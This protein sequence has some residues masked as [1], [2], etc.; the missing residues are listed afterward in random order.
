MRFGGDLAVV[1][2][3]WAVGVPAVSAGL[4]VGS[5]LLSVQGPDV[6]AATAPGRVVITL[7]GLAGY[8]V[9]LF[10][11]LRYTNVIVFF[12]AFLALFTGLN[13][14]S[15]AVTDDALHQRGE[16]TSCTVR[17]VLPVSVTSSDSEGRTQTRIR[18]AYDLDCAVPTVTA[19]ST[20]RRVAAPG[21]RIDVLYD[22]WHR[23]DPRIPDGDED[24][25]WLPGLLLLA[26]AAGL[27]LLCEYGVWPFR[28]HW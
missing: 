22:P 21:D 1:R 11:Q 20:D 27:R 24:S 5:G 6:L 12:G 19:M 10:S 18:Y 2:W 8:C 13:L 3:F 7:I 26:L 25:Q 4:V 17:T 16:L 23:L 9:A 28:A 14:L 15:G